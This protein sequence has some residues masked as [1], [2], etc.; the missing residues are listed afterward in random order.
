MDLM[1]GGMKS[2]GMKKGTLD[3]IAFVPP[4]RPIWNAIETLTKVE[5]QEPVCVM[6][7]MASTWGDSQ[8]A[9]TRHLTLLTQAFQ[10]WGVCEV[11]QT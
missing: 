1:P 4:L 2:L 6:T 5:Q 3:F 9:V 11:T 8:A 10:A 7:I